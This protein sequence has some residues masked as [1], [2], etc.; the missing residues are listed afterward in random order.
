MRATVFPKFSSQRP[1]FW[2]VSDS[3]GVGVLPKQGLVGGH[4]GSVSVSWRPL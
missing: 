4:P 2:S 3:R 1:K